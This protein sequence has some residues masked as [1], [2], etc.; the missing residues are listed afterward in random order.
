M[1]YLERSDSNTTNQLSDVAVV[2]L[3][4]SNVRSVVGSY[5]HDAL[6]YRLI[7]KGAESAKVLGCAPRRDAEFSELQCELSRDQEELY[8]AS[9]QLWQVQFHWECP[10]V[11]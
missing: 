9:V 11:A 4:R 7:E 3:H 10:H 5:K 6:P 1:L 2:L 8:D